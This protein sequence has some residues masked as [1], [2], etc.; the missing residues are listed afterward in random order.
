[1][2]A[3]FAVRWLQNTTTTTTTQAAYNEQQ[4]QERL[5]LRQRKMARKLREERQVDLAHAKVSSEALI[6]ASALRAD[7]PRL[8]VSVG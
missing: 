1:M 3:T 6:T 4:L 7:P 8:S 2:L 5:L